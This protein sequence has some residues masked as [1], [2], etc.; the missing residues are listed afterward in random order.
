MPVPSSLAAV[1][2]TAQK[3]PVTASLLLL[4]CFMLLMSASN[5][6]TCMHGIFYELFPWRF[7][8]YPLAMTIEQPCHI[9]VSAAVIL[10]GASAETATGSSEYAVFLLFTT[11][12]TG[13][14]VFLADLIICTPLQLT[15]FSGSDYY[16]RPYGYVGVWPVAEV[17]AFSL[18]RVRG[19]SAAVGPRLR[20]GQLTLH[21]VPLAIVWVAFGCDM[22]SLVIGRSLDRYDA[23]R[24]GWRVMVACISLI[25]SW[26]Y[27]RRVTGA[28]NA[29][30]AFEA[31]M[32]PAALRDGVRCASGCVQRRL[33]ASP[34]RFLLASEGGVGGGAA[35]LP[36]PVFSRAAVGGALPNSPTTAT[37]TTTVL[38][39][40]TT[41]EEAERHRLIAR[42]ALARRLQQQQQS[43]SV[44]PAVEEAELAAKTV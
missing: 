31:F 1:A 33:Q 15:V 6:L 26:Q 42:E 2:R 4:M 14:L 23:H 40:G 5:D 30:F 37:A 9:A 43:P 8:T 25:V 17:I 13:A 39:P 36:A 10:A 12:V 29:A 28:A 20:N 24:E 41:A 3:M 27:E 21:R 11:V 34:L 38:L 18:C 19:V 35:T 22:V 44:S 7:I 32:Y 16:N